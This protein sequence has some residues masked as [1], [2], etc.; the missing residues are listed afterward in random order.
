[1]NLRRKGHSIGKIEARLGIPR[2]TLSGWF[3]DV[4]LTRAQKEKLRRQWKNGLIKAR[5]KA[6]KWHNAEKEKRIQT[7]KNQ[8]R[9]TIKN[10]DIKDIYLV[11]IAL[12]LLYLGEGSKATTETSMGS[13]D[14]LILKFFLI[15][16]RRI[17]NVNTAKIRCEL[18]LRADQDQQEVKRFWSRELALP[19]RNFTYISVDKRTIGSQTYSHYKG[20]CQIRCGTV[21]IQRKLIDLANMFCEETI[22][23]FG[24]VAQL[25]RARR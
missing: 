13:S 3:K 17:Y 24:L 16:L 1:M 22:K 20:V 23:N 19:I 21:A 12:A 5:K 10:A 15:C 25:V 14:P 4:K 9:E 7:A 18:H 8:A 6:V 2:S 11:E